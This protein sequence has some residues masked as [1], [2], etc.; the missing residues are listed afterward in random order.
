[1]LFDSHLYSH[2]CLVSI[3]I[4]VP[5]LGGGKP[6]GRPSLQWKTREAQRYRI[7]AGAG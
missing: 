7:Y 1:M 4:I 2:A 6:L 5:G 3:F